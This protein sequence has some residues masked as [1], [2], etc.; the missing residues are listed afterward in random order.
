MPSIAA[1]M[2]CAKIVSD[3]LNINDEE[4]IKGNLLPD[5]INIE[6]S[7]H[8]ML[9]KHY[10]IPNIDYFIN[11]IDLKDNLSLGYLTHLLLD[12]YFLEDYIYEVVNGEEVFLNRIMYEEYDIINYKI[13]NKFNIDVNYLNKILINYEVPIDNKKYN[14]NIRCLN[15]GYINETLTYL[16]V[17]NFS[18]FLIDASNNIVKYLKEVKENGYK[19][20]LSNYCLRK[21]N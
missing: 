8:K 6:D 1:H 18:S 19:S 11:N 3:K 21:R 5:I 14:K 15:L 12:K 13:L 2:I 4:F 20:S 17:D 7:H 9:G 16:D 10:Y